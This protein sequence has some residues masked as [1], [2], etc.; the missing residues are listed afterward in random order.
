LAHFGFKSG[1]AVGALEGWKSLVAYVEK[2]E[3][4]AL[5]YTVLLDEKNE[6]I[7][8]VELYENAKFVEEVHVKSEAVKENQKQNGAD[9]TDEKGVVKLKVVQGFF[10]R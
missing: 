3:R 10:G 5:G 6:T 2:N 1:Q 9:R 4:P 7:R 8:T